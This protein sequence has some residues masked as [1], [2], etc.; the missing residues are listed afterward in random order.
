MAQRFYQLGLKKVDVL[1]TLQNQTGKTLKGALSTLESNGCHVMFLEL[2]LKRLILFI[3]AAKELNEIFGLT[4]PNDPR[5]F[6]VDH[7]VP[8]THE[9]VCGFHCHWNL[10]IIT[11]RENAI[12]SNN[13]WPDK[14]GDDLFGGQNYD[15]DGRWLDYWIV[16]EVVVKPLPFQL[17][18]L[19]PDLSPK[20][21]FE[22]A[23]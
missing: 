17:D 8:I 5:Y 10:Q 2:I 20:E 9:D 15:C 18:L 7:I 13:H 1:N 23:L 16:H 11:N 19:S 14:Y 3:N 12:K 21:M 4:D 6:V 22:L